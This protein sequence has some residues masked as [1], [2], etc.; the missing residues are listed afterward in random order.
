MRRMLALCVLVAV[1][2]GAAPAAASTVGVQGTTLAI[3]AATGERNRISV[4]VSGRTIQVT[5]TTST[6]RAGAGCTLAGRTVSCPADGLT[7][8]VADLGDRGDRIALARQVGLRARL[9]GGSGDDVLIGGGGPDELDGGTG[10][11]VVSYA[12]RPDPVTVTVASGA[13][14]GAPGEGDD[15][16]AVERLVGGRGS[17]V[18]TGGGG[19]ERLDGRAGNDRVDG[20]GGSD[21]LVGGAGDDVLAGADGDD[22]F[23]SGSAPEGAD[24]MQG[25][26]G[27][28]RMDYGA[29]TGPVLADPDG[30]PDDGERPGGGLV[31]TG[32]LFNLFGSV[33]AEGDLLMP[34][35]ESVRGGRADD[36]LGAGATGFGRI[37]GGRGTDVLFGG[38]APDRLDGGQG[39]DRLAS[40][41]RSADTL[42]CGTEVDRVFSDDRD[43]VPGDC[44]A[45]S[46]SF[47]VALLVGDRTDDGG[48]RLRVRVACPPQAAVRCVGAV[49]AATVR[50]LRTPGGRLRPAALGAARYNAPAGGAVSVDIVLTEQGRAALARL[51]RTR[52]R[53]AARG[54]DE[55]GPGR[56][57]AARRILG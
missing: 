6:P 57:V 5:D 17:D 1:S 32:P 34:D 10:R 55:A 11:D 52:V 22:S 16:L 14:D 18:L 28:D 46:G 42:I 33:S 20:R 36:V 49:R 38:P 41:D 47:A 51:G 15:V 8:L 7:E 24:V 44:E 3:T 26:S 48:P 50:R 53:V 9:R 29:R 19:R 13:D 39:F 25:G 43:A 4:A 2:A 12:G 54:R 21:V 31:A 27:T 23:V 37:E 56:P 30:R 45:R 40:R 35:V